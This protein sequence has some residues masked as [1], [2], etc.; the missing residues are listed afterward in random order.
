MADP[1]DGGPVP[2]IYKSYL[3]LDEPQF[4]LFFSLAGLNVF[5]KLQCQAFANGC[6]AVILLI[7]PNLKLSSLDFLNISYWTQYLSVNSLDQLTTTHRYITFFWF[8][9]A[10]IWPVHLSLSQTIKI[11]SLSHFLSPLILIHLGF[12][13][14]SI[15]LNFGGFVTRRVAGW[16]VPTTFNNDAAQNLILY[17]EV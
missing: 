10:Y 14:M 4:F 3:F 1:G 15:C 13:W 2:V 6:L 16:S 12:Y 7:L 5:W 17:Y 9:L 11:S 8:L